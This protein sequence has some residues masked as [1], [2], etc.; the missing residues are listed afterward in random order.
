M[1]GSETEELVLHKY[2]FGE[3]VDEK[4]VQHVVGIAGQRENRE[5]RRGDV[6]DRRSESSQ[7][8]QSDHLRSPRSASS[9]R[10]I[11]GEKAEGG[12]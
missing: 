8:V 9:S 3:A 4:T 12:L 5:N 11:R 7:V 10:P 2:F 1:N 6:R